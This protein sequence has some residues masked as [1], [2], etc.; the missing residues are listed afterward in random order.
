MQNITGQGIHVRINDFGMDVN[1]EEL[2]HRFDSTKSCSNF[3][4]NIGATAFHGTAVASI[5]AAE[6]N[7]SECAVGIAPGVTLSACNFDQDGTELELIAMLEQQIDFGV[8][9]SLNS[10][11]PE[12]CTKWKDVRRIRHLQPVAV[13]QSTGDNIDDAKA[14]NNPCIFDST[15]PQSPCRICDDAMFAPDTDRE[16]MSEACVSAIDNYC[17]FY[18]A[19]DAVACAEFLDYYVRCEYHTLPPAAHEVFLDQMLNG[20]NGK[21]IIYVFAGGNSNEA[22]ATTNTDGFINSRF[23]IAVG[24][25]DKH[26]YHA[27]YSTTG[28][29]LHV[30]APGGAV[31]SLRNNIVA[32]AG[33]GCTE[34][35]GGTS[36]SAPVVAGVVALM[37]EANPNL[38]WRDVQ[39]ILAET[40]QQVDPTDDSWTINNDG[41]GLPVSY[42][43]GFGLVDAEA[44]VNLS[45]S[46]MNIG[47]EQQLVLT[48]EPDLN[49]LIVDDKADAPPL[50][51][52]QY[53]TGA[54]PNFRIESVVLYL[55]LQHASRGD[56]KITLTSPSGT[57]SILHPAKR[58]ENR[59][60]PENETWKLMTVRN[61]YENP[62]GEWKL[63]IS[64][65]RPGSRSNCADE[66]YEHLYR[67][68]D[69]YWN[70]YNCLDAEKFVHCRNGR[71]R[72]QFADLI[73][74]YVDHERNNQTA[75]QACCVCGGGTPVVDV[76]MLRSWT[77]IV[78]GH[79]KLMTEDESAS[80]SSSG[81]STAPTLVAE[82]VTTIKTPDSSEMANNDTS[83][84]SDIDATLEATHESDV[85]EPDMELIAPTSSSALG[86]GSS[87]AATILSEA[88]SYNGSRLWMPYYFYLL[89]VFLAIHVLVA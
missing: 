57:E 6:A 18:Y 5:L 34:V 87:E 69:G 53:L 37:L 49:L 88:S 62:N 59:Q 65:E 74:E 50:V 83:I 10:W 86:D 48:S 89:A 72:D 66:P 43:Y 13:R 15:H 54:S 82:T 77:V 21:G 56:L 51:H 67:H 81:P 27:S 9:I 35:V 84:I 47:P 19:Q 79:D 60:L 68:R 14:N 22:G 2:K 76:D 61:W 71:I 30:V 33:G 46:W 75:S 32:N 42:K 24:G 63:S 85:Q 17:T 8:D 58:P 31:G 25:V 78:Y 41:A 52:S 40:A 64:D 45:K 55:G 28:S 20:R 80:S 73:S 1:H 39:C 16:D 12:T 4:S 3:Q 26:G 11:G 70:V 7:N 38:G 29:A 36:F 44:S 23:T